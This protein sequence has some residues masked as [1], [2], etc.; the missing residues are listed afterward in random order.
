M[1]LFCESPSLGPLMFHLFCGHICLS[2][3]TLVFN[4][5]LLLPGFDCLYLPFC[6]LKSVFTYLDRLRLS[7]LRFYTTIMRKTI[8]SCSG[9]IA[10]HF[11]GVSRTSYLLSTTV[12]ICLGV[13]SSTSYQHIY[14]YMLVGSLDAG[15]YRG[16]V[17]FKLG[18][19]LPNALSGGFCVN[20]FLF[21]QKFKQQLTHRCFLHCAFIEFHHNLQVCG[22]V[23]GI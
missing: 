19:I 11:T 17:S 4:L 6:F 23:D 1:F 5:P 8:C 16:D 18:E 12:I 22:F 13:M 3:L 2:F 9:H 15:F 10:L 7:S 20:Y 21:H 14:L